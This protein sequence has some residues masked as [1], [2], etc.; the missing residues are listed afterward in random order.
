[1]KRM[2]IFAFTLL[3]IMLFC[4]SCNHLNNDP[5][6]MTEKSSPQIIATVESTKTEVSDIITESTAV[7]KYGEIEN[8]CPQIVDAET[9]I[10]DKITEVF[11]YD[12]VKK[13][14][15]DESNIS[16][17]SK[18]FNVK[19]FKSLPSNNK[20][21]ERVKGEKKTSVYVDSHYRTLVMTTNGYMI[22]DYYIGEKTIEENSVITFIGNGELISYK[23]ITLSKE[24]IKNQIIGLEVGITVDDVVRIDPNGKYD[25]LH[26]GWTGRPKY[27]YHYFQDGTGVEIKYDDANWEIE[28]ITLFYL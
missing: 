24:E 19:Y 1:M 8:D 6:L 7:L 22:I 10:I 16:M 26:T 5:I 2:N 12:V 27:S 14:L 4:I 17:F 25:F 18:E 9:I 11:D 13:A 3:A 21:I 20:I 15:D 23:L 28:K